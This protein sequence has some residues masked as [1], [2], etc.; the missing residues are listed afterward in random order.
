M[1]NQTTLLSTTMAA[2]AALT[3]CQAP[4]TDNQQ[5][6]PEPTEA[7]AQPIIGGDEALPG[8]WPWQV[9]LLYN[10]RHNCG[11]SLLSPEWVLTA[12]HCVDG[13]DINKITLKMGLH[14]RSAP[15][16]WVQTRKVDR[17]HIHPSF[18]S[19]FAGNDVALLH[20]PQPVA[21]NARIQPITLRTTAAPVGVTA[22]VTGWGRT[23]AADPASSSD[24]M[25]EATV[26][27]VSTP[28]CAPSFAPSP[29]TS[30]MLCAGYPAGDHGGCRGDSGGP[31]VIP[32][33][34]SS[35]WQQVGIVSWGHGDCGTYTVY[36]R[37]SEL[38][39]WVDGIVGTAPVYGDVNGSGCV[40]AADLAVIT[41]FYGQATNPGN[42]HADLN[43]DGVINFSDRLIVIQ[44][45]GEG[46]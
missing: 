29:I 33:G 15:D 8:E 22:F 37:I 35:G 13:F 5:P 19:A 36:S 38:A 3:A 6:T 39:A 21:Y 43:H 27:L 41:G 28:T 25:L 18:T 4:G 20:M 24:V 14:K 45:L 2:L 12:A 26:P 32:T 30:T 34:F 16:A 44:N 10:G 7:L 23:V 1:R 17:A 40:D 11:A 31:L 9:E 46:C 42:Q